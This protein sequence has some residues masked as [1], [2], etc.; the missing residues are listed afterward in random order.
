MYRWNT[1]LRMARERA[2]LSLAK[3]VDLLYKME[4]VRI[5]RTFLG[6]VERGESDLTTSK[7]RALCKLYGADPR[8][9]LDLEEKKK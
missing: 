4:K 2:R 7:F 9:I 8:W 6:Q 1:R 5:H 3:A